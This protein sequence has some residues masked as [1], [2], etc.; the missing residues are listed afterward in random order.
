MNFHFLHPV[1]LQQRRKIK[2]L[3]HTLFA[4]E[5]KSLH[6]LDIIF[7]SDAYLLDINRKFLS[8]DYFTDII[9]FDLA[10]V[11]GPTEGEIYISVD[12]ARTNAKTYNVL[13]SNELL[14]LII[15]GSLHLC[16]FVD[17]TPRDKNRMSAKENQYLSLFETI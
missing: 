3:V 10:G 11:D 9:T 13:L 2:H 15:H 14:R 17:K 1:Q 6:S 7:C 8:H 16:G 12:T 5:Q 4:S